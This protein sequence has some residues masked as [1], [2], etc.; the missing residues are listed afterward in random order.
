MAQFTL[1]WDSDDVVALENATAQRASYKARSSPTWITDGFTPAND[2]A[3]EV[4]SAT[5]PD[6]LL[7]NVVY[8]TKVEAICTVN[9][10]TINDNGVQEEIN[11]ACL[12]SPTIET[13]FES[14]ITTFDVD[15]TDIYKAHFTLR[16]AS[17]NS[18]V[19]YEDH[20]VNNIPIYQDNVGHLYL[21]LS[22]FKY[23]D[24]EPHIE[25]ILEPN[26]NYYWQLELFAIV[27]NVSV[28]SKLPKYLT[29]LCSPYPFTTDAPPVCDPITAGTISSIEIP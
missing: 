27:N 2:M 24:A 4:E 21:D 12:P 23:S 19:V 14:A 16:K 18:I 26:T 1:N 11:F 20:P 10:P 15:G 22:D 9:G 7:D 29:V 25:I 3:K 8:Q 28:S 6:T 5:T 13:T 17:D